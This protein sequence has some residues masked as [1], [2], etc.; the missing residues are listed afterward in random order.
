M[1]KLTAKLVIETLGLKPLPGEGGYF[2]QT[3]RSDETIPAAALPG[4]FSTDRIFGSAIYYLLTPTEYSALH[5]L[6][7]DEIFHFYLGDPVTQLQLLPDGTSRV[8][9]LGPDILAGQAP[10]VVAPRGAWQGSFLNPGGSF[11]LLGATNAPGFE[12]EDLE[13]PFGHDL[14]AIWPEQRDLI[15]RLMPGGN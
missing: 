15:A 2:A 10:Q 14:A 11:A 7:T 5:R 13:L 8:V 9:T 4:R 1:S 6:P 3:Y 12:D